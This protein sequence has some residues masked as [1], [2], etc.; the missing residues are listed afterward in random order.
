MNKVVPTFLAMSV[1]LIAAGCSSSDSRS[2][3]HSGVKAT[4]VSYTAQ[5]QTECANCGAGYH[6]AAH[7][8][9]NNSGNAMRHSHAGAA[10]HVHGGYSA[11]YGYITNTTVAS[12]RNTLA[13][14][15]TRSVAASNGGGSSALVKIAGALLIGGLIYSATKDD[16]DD[17]STKNTA[18]CGADK[19]TC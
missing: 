13:T 10:G 4:H 6:S 15:G 2:G 11:G 16:D 12:G 5:S 17:S 3:S 8:H 14:Q 9:S 18:G 19:P 7:A 1:S